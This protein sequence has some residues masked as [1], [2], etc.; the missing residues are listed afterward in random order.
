MNRK[1]PE[2][3]SGLSMLD[4]F[5][6]ETENLTA[7]LTAGLLELER[8]PVTPQQLEALMRAAHSLKGAARLVNLPVAVRLAHAMEDC[9]VLAQQGQISLGRNHI[10]ALFR[11][12]DSLTQISK[13]SDA[14]IKRWET[15][16]AGEIVD[17]LNTLT[18]LTS[19]PPPPAPWPNPRT[20]RPP[21]RHQ[22]NRPP[23][24]RTRHCS[25]GR[26]LRTPWSGCPQRI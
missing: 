25:A 26:M 11:G 17:L 7:I 4:L 13:S 19:A 24:Q 21:P 5:R 8:G 20:S 2:D 6:V 1:P 18:A 12:V 9:F 16:R 10:D 14:E 3:L 22:P 15:D 23:R